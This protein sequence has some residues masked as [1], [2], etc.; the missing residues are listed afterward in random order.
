[1]SD[2]KKIA[3]AV[4]ARVAL[5]NATNADREELNRVWLEAVSPLS[6]EEYNQYRR[7]YEREINKPVQ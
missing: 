2:Q 6:D 4:K 7:D 1:M 5:G 3:K